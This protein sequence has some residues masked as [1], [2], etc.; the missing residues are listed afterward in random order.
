MKMEIRKKWAIL[1]LLFDSHFREKYSGY[2]ELFLYRIKY[3]SYNRNLI[4]FFTH[5]Y[6]C[7]TPTGLEKITKTHFEH[8]FF[9]TFGS[10]KNM[11]TQQLSDIGKQ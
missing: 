4:L 1:K 2:F 9:K 5:N 11:F 3:R 8:T 10:I 7:S 6:Y